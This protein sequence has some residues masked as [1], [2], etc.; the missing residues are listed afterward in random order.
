MAL[1]SYKAYDSSG[2]KVDGQIE[3]LD[4]A[5]ALVQLKQQGLLTTEVKAKP[6]KVFLALTIRYLLRI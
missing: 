5:T 3:S 2:A 4:K 1:F 6:E